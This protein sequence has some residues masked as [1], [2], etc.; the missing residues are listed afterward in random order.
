V[1]CISLTEPVKEIG[2]SIF[3]WAMTTAVAFIGGFAG[4]QLVCADRSMD[5]LDSLAAID[6][7]NYRYIAEQGYSYHEGEASSVAFFPVFPLAGRWL[8][9][10]TGLSVACSLLLISNCFC[11]FT[12]I[13]MSRYLQFRGLQADKVERDDRALAI[14]A[15]GLIPTTFFFHVAYTESMFVCLAV[16]T[17]YGIVRC[18]SVTAIALVVGLATGVRPVGVSLLLP[19]CA[20]SCRR[21]G[22]NRYQAIARVVMVIPVGSWGLLVYMGFLARSFGQPF[23]FALTQKYHRMRP[24]GTLGDEVMS[25]LSW[26]PIRDTYD[27]TSPG[28]WQAMHYVRSRLFSL[29]FANPIY[30]LGT[31]ALIALGAWKRWLTRDELLLAVPLLVIPY[32]TRAYEMRMLSQARFAAVVFPAYIVI[33][34]MLARLPRIVAV[35]VLALS[36]FM[37]GIYTALFAAGY[38]FL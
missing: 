9:H 7:R 3:C 13:F 19:L 12:F 22:S 11:L 35:S 15:M 17:F 32:V 21:S 25:L 37:M 5:L 28:Y 36:G 33:G 20:Y 24:I 18:W 16:V 14:L 10:F 6:G 29:E 23:A 1:R 2:S 8:S 31:A 34:E 26:E 27:P 38:P 30:L 4:C